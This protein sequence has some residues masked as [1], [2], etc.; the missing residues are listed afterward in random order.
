M[1]FNTI[2]GGYGLLLVV[3]AVAPSAVQ[4]N[5]VCKASS[6][7]IAKASENLR[8]N[9]N[10]VRV[11]RMDVGTTQGLPQRLDLCIDVRHFFRLLDDAYDFFFCLAGIAIW[12]MDQ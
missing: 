2:A 7:I 8:H 12:S 1:V 10:L 4:K 5:G 11:Y 3:Q 6:C 9:L